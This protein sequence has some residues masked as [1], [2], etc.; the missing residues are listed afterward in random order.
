MSEHI[1]KSVPCRRAVVCAALAALVGLFASCGNGKTESGL[2]V[3]SP[4]GLLPVSVN[5]GHELITYVGRTDRSVPSAPRQWAGG[6]YFTFAYDGNGCDIDLVDEQLWGSDYNYMEI[7]VDTLPGVRV[8]HQ[9]KANRIVIGAAQQPDSVATVGLNVIRVHGDIAPGPHRVMVVRDTE[10]AMGFTQLTKLTSRRLM[11]WTPETKLR[12]EFIGNSI[13]SGTDSYLDEVPEGGKWY[14]RHRAYTAYGPTTARALG[15]QW[16]LASVSGI[17]LVH[18]CC[19]HKNVM[20]EL[21]DKVDLVANSIPYD[22]S[23][24]PDIVVSALGQNDGAQDSAYF[25]ES[26][27]TFL[28]SIVDRDPA[29]R[30]VLISSPMADSALREHFRSVLPAV[31]ADLDAYRDSIGSDAPRTVWHIYEKSY[32]SGYTTHPS[33]AEHQEIAAELVQVLRESQDKLKIS[34]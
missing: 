7:V 23:F 6:A 28:K 31:A 19:D 2:A 18:S 14:D 9:G 20:P 1:N 26:Y 25:V 32:N 16:S 34:F 29:V 15:A 5:G 27:S 17:G 21:Y 30:I 11:Q 22:F 13:T 12:M 4:D 24:R 8:R 3:Q 10:S 33:M